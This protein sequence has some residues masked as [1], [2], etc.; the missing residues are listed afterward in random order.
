MLPEVHLRDGPLTQNIAHWL[1][2]RRPQETQKLV[3][4]WCMSYLT[5]HGPGFLGKFVENHKPWT[6]AVDPGSTRLRQGCVTH[7]AKIS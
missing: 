2:P 1:Q 4:T 6:V 3:D 5:F 7:L